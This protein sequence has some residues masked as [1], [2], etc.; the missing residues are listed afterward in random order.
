MSSSISIS[1]SDG[2]LSRVAG[3]DVLLAYG[4]A[5]PENGAEGYATGCLF[6]HT[7]GAAGD[8]V[9]VN[10]GTGDLSEF[11]PLASGPLTASE[12]GIVDT[13]AFTTATN[14]ES[15]IAEIYQHLLSSSGGFIDLPLTGWREVDAGGDVGNIVNNGGVLASDTTPKLGGD[16]ANEFMEIVWAAGVVDHAAYATTLPA[17]FDGTVNCFIDLYVKSGGT[18]NATS[19]DVATTWDGGVKGSVTASG[20]ASTSM[21]TATATIAAGDIPDS[22]KTLTVDLAANTHATDSFTLLGA[23]LRY[24]RKLLTS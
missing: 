14:T 23:R 1:G 2:V 20:S 7:N 5:V 8:T 9:H 3:D 21:H 11:K 22:P 4:P 15:A 17:D 24:K 12:V 19:F 13:G 10:E 18:T 6:L 16:A